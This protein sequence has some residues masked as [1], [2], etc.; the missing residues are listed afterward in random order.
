MDDSRTAKKLTGSIVLIILLIIGLA[1][2]TIALIYANVSLENNLFHTGEVKL[3]LN[4]EKPV[5]RED[6][7][8]FEPGMTVKKEFFIENQSTWDVYYK[9]YLSDVSGGLAD[10]LEVTVKDGD[11]IVSK[12]TPN[13]LARGK[14]KSAEEALKI[15]QRKTLTVYFYYPKESGNETQNRNLTFTICAD[16]TQTKNNPERKFD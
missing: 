12:G 6:E 13:E 11:Q 5:I 2:T 8:L 3:N 10:V 4:D 14:V 9:I 1:V 16:A 7:F 15:G